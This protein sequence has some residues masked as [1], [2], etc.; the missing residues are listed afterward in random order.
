MIRS[1][2]DTF[3]TTAN[4]DQTAAKDVPAV[5]I[6]GASTGIGLACALEL[7]RR[8]YQVFAGVRKEADAQRLRGQGSPRLTPVML[9]ITIDSSIQ[10][11]AQQIREAVGSKGLAGLINNAGAALVGPVEMVPM[12]RI[13]Q[14]FEVNVFGHLA[15]SQALIPLL[16]IAH[17]RLINISSLNGILPVPFFGPY[18]ASKYALEAFSDCMRVELAKW[19]IHVVVVEPGGVRTP[20]WEK[21]KKVNEEV[22]GHAP[23]TVMDLYGDGIAAVRK[24]AAE[25]ERTGQPVER[26]V[27]AVWQALTARRPKTRYLCGFQTYLSRML[28]RWCSDR[29]RDR[30]LGN[31]LGVKYYPPQFPVPNPQTR[32]PKPQTPIPNP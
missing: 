19:G 9:D 6:T 26:I 15:V 2:T 1:S 20:I 18:T 30:I 14:Q 10:S 13:R 8:G 16:R 11:A 32:I 31:M 27:E 22:L 3:E 7:D 24:S 5:V 21:S 12:D 23:P 4:T 29:F 17:G 25:M 28:K